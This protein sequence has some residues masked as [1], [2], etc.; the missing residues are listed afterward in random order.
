M[1]LYSILIDPAVTRID[2]KQ[3]LERLES[4]G[5]QTRPVWAPAHLMPFYAGAPRLGG[6][7]GDRLFAHGLSLPC[8]TGLTDTDAERVIDTVRALLAQG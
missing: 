2:R 5:I 4:S 1:W 3:M 6:A 8:S 7:V